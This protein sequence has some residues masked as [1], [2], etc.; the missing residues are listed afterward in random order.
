MRRPDVV[1]LAHGGGGKAS[2]ELVARIF[3]PAFKNRF[4]ETLSDGALL[5]PP[6]GRIVFTTDSFV[7]D[8]IFFP[9]GDIGSLAVHGTVNDLAVSGAEPRYLSAGFII[10][11]GFPM[12]DLKRVADSMGRA[13]ID[14]GV[15]IVAGDTK[16]VARG[17]ADKLFINTAGIGVVPPGVSISPARVQDGDVLILSGPI[18]D[19]GMAVLTKRKGLDFKTPL[20]SDSRPLNGL[21]REMLSAEPDIRM[22][23]DATRGGLAAVLCEI[24]RASGRGVMMDEKSIPVSEGARAVCELLGMDPLHVANEGTLAAFVPA[25]SAEKVLAAMRR[26]PYGAQA[27][28]IGSAGGAAPGT[29]EMKTAFLGSRIIEPLAGDQL[30]RIC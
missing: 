2:A 19:H 22:M 7:I 16:V 13:A 25:A 10:E 14:A 26:H 29:V 1:T 28:I 18:A 12:E 5:P 9:G 23:R 4:L 24:A 6:E 30:P 17:A 21:V 3:L 15:N 27:A 8:P 20:I 11:E